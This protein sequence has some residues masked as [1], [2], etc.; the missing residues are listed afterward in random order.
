[1]HQMHVI[2]ALGPIDKRKKTVAAQLLKIMS[3]KTD[4][5]N[6]PISIRQ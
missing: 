2:Y 4:G 1:M 6:F 3:G 5:V